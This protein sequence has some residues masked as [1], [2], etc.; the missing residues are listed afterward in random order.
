MNKT[1]IGLMGCVGL[2]VLGCSAKEPEPEAKSEHKALYKSV[3]ASLQKG[4]DVED[5]VMRQ[6]E[7]QRQQIDR[8]TE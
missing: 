3:D 5:Q 4:R 2:A 8:Q 7:E 1:L 6:A